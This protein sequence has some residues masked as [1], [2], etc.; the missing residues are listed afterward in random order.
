M[1]KH[2]VLSLKPQLRPEWRGQDGQNET[3]Q[4]DH[5]ASLSDSIRSSTRDKFFSTHGGP[6][7]GAYSQRVFSA[8]YQSSSIADVPE[9][10]SRSN[11]AVS[12]LRPSSHARRQA[13]WSSGAVGR[14]AISAY[15]SRYLALAG[16]QKLSGWN[17]AIT[18]T[19]A[20]GA[21]SAIHSSTGYVQHSVWLGITRWRI[22]KS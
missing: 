3:E 5:S 7:F 8:S 20:A 4:P 21:R 19:G 22:E 9:A 17:C 2:R 14:G 1:S 10:L 15:L 16:S 12:H 18:F 11:E 6:R 13:S